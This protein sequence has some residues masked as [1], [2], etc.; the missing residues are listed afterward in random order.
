MRVSR[1]VLWR[2]E[3]DPRASSRQRIVSV[4]R[5]DPG[6]FRESAALASWFL[7]DKSSRSRCRSAA[8]CDDDRFELVDRPG[9]V[10]D[11]GVVDDLE[12]ADRLDAAVTRLRCAGR[13]SRDHCTRCRDSVNGVGLAVAAS[14]L[15]IGTIDLDH[16]DTSSAQ[17]SGEARA[18]AASH[19]R[20][21]TEPC[22]SS[23]N[24]A[25]PI[26]P[27]H[28]APQSSPWSGAQA[29]P[30][31]IAITPAASVH[32][33]IA[34]ASSTNEPFGLSRRKP[35]ARRG[36]APVT[37]AVSRGSLVRSARCMRSE[38]RYVRRDADVKPCAASWSRLSS[39]STSTRCTN[40][41]ARRA[42]RSQL[43]TPC[44]SASLPRTSSPACEPCST[45]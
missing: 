45:K 1:R 40:P 32:T 17:V 6:G 36:A 7:S 4:A 29:A 42:S 31:C 11:G 22:Q 26:G 3:L 33:S 19:P 5:P 16:L 18:P 25:P 10:H 14:C 27:V 12:L 43:R 41:H 15:A 35:A 30:A 28:G 2:R 23:P 24:P 37:N 21:T 13:P 44:D 8:S 38:R 20:R 34:T 9:P 39:D